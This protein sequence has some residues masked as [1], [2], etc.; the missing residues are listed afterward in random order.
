M[1]KLHRT[2]SEIPN[3]PLILGQLLGPGDFILHTVEGGLAP[4]AYGYDGIPDGLTVNPTTQ[5]VSGAP[6]QVGVFTIVQ[7]VTD[8][9]GEKLV[10]RTVVHVMEGEGSVEEE[11]QQQQGASPEATQD[12]LLAA[13]QFDNAY[14]AA[15][16]VVA[17]AGLVFTDAKTELE[18]AK[19]ELAA[20][21]LETVAEHDRRRAELEAWRKERGQQEEELGQR[22]DQARE[23]VK[24][25]RADRLAQ[26]RI[27]RSLLGTFIDEEEAALA[28]EQ[29]D[30]AEDEQEAQD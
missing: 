9:T 17:R 7:T 5:E 12:P 22:I 2:S 24:A 29:A 1:E 3:R 13:P 25:K 11:R 20:H 19:K 14:D 10:S 27:L 6:S 30:R 23:T 16:D 28:A 21:E 8:A 26:A 15:A 4:L 18:D